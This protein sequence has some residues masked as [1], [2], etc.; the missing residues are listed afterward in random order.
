MNVCKM[1]DDVVWGQSET[2]WDETFLLVM[3]ETLGVTAIVNEVMR[4]AMSRFDEYEMK[5]R[6]MVSIYESLGRTEGVKRLMVHYQD[7]M[8]RYRSAHDSCMAIQFML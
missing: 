3:R 2:V 1:I 7:I 4:W 6:K 5:C 8:M